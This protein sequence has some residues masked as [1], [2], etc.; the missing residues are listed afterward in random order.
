ME[1][2]GL[3]DHLD[4]VFLLVDELVDKGYSCVCVCV[5]VR[6]RVCEGSATWM[7]SSY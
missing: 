7:Q 5:R 4:A 2:K 3:L 6:V 1:K